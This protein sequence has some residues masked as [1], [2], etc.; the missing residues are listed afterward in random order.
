MIRWRFETKLPDSG[1]FKESIQRICKAAKIEKNIMSH[2]LGHI[3]VTDLIKATV[4]S[5]STMG[6]CGRQLSEFAGWFSQERGARFLSSPRK[7][8]PKICDAQE[9]RKGKRNRRHR[10]ENRKSP[11]QAL[12]QLSNTLNMGN[13]HLNLFF[14]RYITTTGAGSVSKVFRRQ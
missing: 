11:A 10:K 9:T 2:I 12:H 14:S 5:K 8:G 3:R 7:Q 4:E 6:L 13:A 1:G